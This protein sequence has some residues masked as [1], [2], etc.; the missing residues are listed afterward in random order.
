M[1]L[2]QDVAACSTLIMKRDLFYMRLLLVVI[3]AVFIAACAS[4]GRPEGGPLDETPPRFVRSN[5]AP[6]SRNVNV[7]RITIMFDENVQVKDVM[8]KVVVSPPQSSMP[9]VTAVGRG[10]RIELVDT[11]LPNTTYTVD[12]TDAISDLNEDNPLDGFAFD[13]STGP[14]IDSLCI[15]G[16]VFEAETLEPAQGMLVGVHSNLADSA[17]STLPFERITRTNQYG[18]F[19]VRNLKEGTYRIFAL[20]DVNR[21]NK[22]DRSENVAFYDVT[23][24]PS[25]SRVE[26]ADTLVASDGSDSIVARMA[27]AFAPDDVLLTWFNENYKSQYLAKY[28]RRDHNRIYFEFGAKS[29]TFP[30]LR[31]VGGP[32]DGELIDGYTV[33]NA[34]VTRDTLDYWITDSS[35]IALDSIALSATYLRTDTLDQLSWGTD[36]LN[37]NIRKSK[38]KKK[39]EKQTKKNDGDSTSV[40]VPTV[41]LLKL[42]IVN[43]GTVDVF[44]PISVQAEQPIKSLDNSMVHLEMMVDTLWQPVDMPPLVMADSLKPMSLT[45]D[46]KWEPGSKYRLT[47][48]S[49]A[50]TG[51]YDEWNGKISAEFT[52]RPLSDYANL[53][54]NISGLDDPAM[55]QLLN[56][57]DKPVKTVA[58]SNRRAVI[59]NILPNTYY[60]R[61]FIDRNGNGKYDTGN[62][63]EKL[64]PED[65]Y[66][67]P[68]KITLKKNWDVAETWNI[69]E[70]PVDMQKPLDIKKNKPK[71]KKGERDT[72]TDE[73]DE[74][75]YDEFGNP[76][77]DPDDPFGKRKNHRYNSLE[78][79]DRN[80]HTQGAGY[81]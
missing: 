79:R 55:V 15:S 54:F 37:F 11:L 35:V 6:G 8:T 3:A 56:N 74:Q 52:V 44:S 34:S 70:T 30:E 78:G 81:R 45:A 43:N 66:Y 40:D 31:F 41:T 9:K 46:Y 27:T 60:A 26:V 38:G 42:K 13:F 1:S 64:Q 29:D 67:Y 68:K 2:S 48:D 77:V 17:I 59:T 16:M 19:T 20:D 25:S 75:Y 7:D 5:P 62:L 72:M 61:L 32:H 73:D 12:F 58:V 14:T 76:A 50:I 51:I 49:L 33:L 23:V 36:T 63:K 80:T 22:W 69:Y 57:Q 24:T 65:T 53:T 18:Q 10:V 21:D 71:K 4:M 39:E 28:E 47:I